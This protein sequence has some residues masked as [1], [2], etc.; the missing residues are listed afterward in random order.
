MAFDKMW[1]SW[2]RCLVHQVEWDNNEEK[3]YELPV[4]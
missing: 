2:M 1:I 3:N 4:Q